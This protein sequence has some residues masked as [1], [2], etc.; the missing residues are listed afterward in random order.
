[1]AVETIIN[2]K[3]LVDESDA[4]NSSEAISGANVYRGTVLE[5]IGVVV[6]PCEAQRTPASQVPHTVPTRS[7]EGQVQIQDDE[8]QEYFYDE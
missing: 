2:D 6:E 3:I 1:M 8:I 4:S 5:T 7:G